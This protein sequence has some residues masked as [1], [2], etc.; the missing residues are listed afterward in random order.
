MFLFKILK[1][2]NSILSNPAVTTLKA[3]KNATFELR[4]LNIFYVDW[5]E[6]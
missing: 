5:R 6:N 1:N 3:L 2:R 4:T